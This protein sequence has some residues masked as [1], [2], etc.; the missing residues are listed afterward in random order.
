MARAQESKDDEGGQPSAGATDPVS[1][2]GD[3]H[4]GV[5]PFVEAYEAY[6]G[7]LGESLSSTT[8]AERMAEAYRTYTA[9]MS[10]AWAPE[11]ASDPIGEATRNLM[12]AQQQAGV[13]EDVRRRFS[14]A[15]QHGV[16]LL[17]DA[18]AADDSEQVCADA[19]DAYLRKVKGAI[20]RLD[21]PSSLVLGTV[22]ESLVAAAR[23]A[24]S[25][26]AEVAH[27]RAAV[28]ALRPPT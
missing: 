4:D 7:A 15:Q 17:E 11:G 25:A 12:R 13:P 2:D 27:R 10:G 28:A 1:A 6:A 3:R 18:W 21:K 14:D 20:S 24:R 22:G 8:L 5:Q 26:E 19:L 9:E 23:L 16:A